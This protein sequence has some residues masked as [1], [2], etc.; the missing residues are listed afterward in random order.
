MLF[1]AEGLNCNDSI[2]GSQP[3]ATLPS[4]PPL[5]GRTTGCGENSGED[6]YCKS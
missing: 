3:S 1:S 4:N 5:G 6:N 2:W